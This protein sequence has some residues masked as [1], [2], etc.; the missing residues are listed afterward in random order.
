MIKNVREKCRKELK[1][2]LWTVFIFG[3]ATTLCGIL[4]CIDE[5]D[6]YICMLFLLA[7]LMISRVT[8]GYLYGIVAAIMG[9]FFVNYVFTYP[10]FQF[11]FT[12]SGYPLTFIT[13]M[14]TSL[15]TSTLTSQIKAQEAL[16]VEN[17][18]EKMRA[19][20]LRAVSHDLRT[21]L[22]SIAG[23][24]SAIIENDEMIAKEERLKLLEEAREDAK[25][26]IHMVENLLLVTRVST[27]G[28]EIATQLEMVEE[29]IAEAVQ[30][31]KKYFP[32]Q[33]ITVK[34]PMEVL[35]VPMDATL[36]EQV[37][38][39]MLENAVLHGAGEKPIELIVKAKRKAVYFY[40]RDY[41]KGIHEK[42]LPHLF[43]DYFYHAPAV[44]EDKKK[45]MGIGLSVCK[46]IIEAHHGKIGVENASGGGAVFWFTLPIEE[47]EKERI[48]EG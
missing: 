44:E 1:N 29:V 18:R 45:N 19:N 8:T 39:N 27:K 2:I 14:A 28:A 48:E 4:R 9:V 43:E 37:I 33:Q 34:V 13:M 20:L 17:E 16:R 26:L 7:V 24:T 32:N 31:F 47:T 25:W 46:S 42:E 21:P 36:I 41:G 30:K 23:I 38:G 35:M 11:N 40:I 12:I 3:I 6:I 10:Y 15:I 22:T 5:G